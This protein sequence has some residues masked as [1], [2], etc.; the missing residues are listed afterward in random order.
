MRELSVRFAR[1]QNVR[2]IFEQKWIEGLTSEQANHWLNAADTRRESI[3]CANTAWLK[4]QLVEIG[5]FT[6]PKY[7]ADADEAAWHLVQHADH[8]P[9]F[10]HEMLARLQSLP[11]GQTDGKRLGKLVDRV[12]RS[13]GRLQKYGTQGQCKDGQWTPF[14][15]EDPQALDARR[16]SLGME[17]IAELMKFNSRENCQR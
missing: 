13:E 14:E 6:V 5:W 7:G 8:E 1:D 16:A 10:Q 17:S 11:L 4:A 9:S 3:D 12:A 15:S 2:Q